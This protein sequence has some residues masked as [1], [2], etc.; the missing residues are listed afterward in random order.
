M[1][2]RHKQSLIAFGFLVLT[3]CTAPSVTTFDGGRLVT[4]KSSSILSYAALSGNKITLGGKTVKVTPENVTWASGGSLKLPAVWKFLEL[5]EAADGI[6]VVVDGN[7][8]ATI[9]PA[10]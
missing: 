2:I 8:I 9:H 3:G 10:T 5:D 1:P 6:V 4:G 7:R